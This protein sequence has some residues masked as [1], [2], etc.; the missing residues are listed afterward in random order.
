MPA[1]I[2]PFVMQLTLSLSCR[3]MLGAQVSTIESPWESAEMQVLQTFILA[4]TFSVN[5]AP[6]L[7]VSDSSIFE[8]RCIPISPN[9]KLN[10][11]KTAESLKAKVMQ[12]H[13]SSLARK[14]EKTG[15]SNQFF[16]QTLCIK[17]VIRYVVVYAKQFS[18]RKCGARN[19]GDSLLIS[20]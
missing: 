19:H 18:R 9:R 6:M 11:L 8:G 5:M 20:E 16:M 14:Q 4:H 17:C 13:V 1:A 10:A 7:S 15:K 3:G 2:N 12:G